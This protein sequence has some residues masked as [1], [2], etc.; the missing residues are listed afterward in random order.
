MN[1]SG[2][3]VKEYFRYCSL[4]P[5]Q[6]I[7]VVD[8]ADLPLGE[9]KLK[10]FGGSAGH[11]GLRSIAKELAC[12]FKRLKVGIGRPSTPLSLADFVLMTQDQAFW[13]KLEP[14]MDQAVS[15]LERLAKETFEN[16]MKAANT[17]A[18]NGEKVDE[19]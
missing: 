12:N 4:D 8:D 16:V 7:V 18:A 15:L 19:T 6:L 13:E 11:N 10:P 17:R 2:E 5:R 14:V 9:M 3:A 1:L